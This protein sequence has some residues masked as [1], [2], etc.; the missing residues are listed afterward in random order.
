MNT[1]PGSAMKNLRAAGR[2]ILPVHT[3]TPKVSRRTQS[4]GRST[5]TL[6]FPDASESDHLRQPQVNISSSKLGS[7]TIFVDGDEDFFSFER[8]ARVVDETVTCILVGSASGVFELKV[9]IEESLELLPTVEVRSIRL[10]PPRSAGV[11]R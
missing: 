7:G 2:L 6:L 9:V 8:S 11:P 1:Q 4:S 3:R 10:S 5:Y